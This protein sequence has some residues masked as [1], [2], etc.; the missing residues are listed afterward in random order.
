MQLLA[1]ILQSILLALFLMQDTVNLAPFNNLAAQI[2]RLGWAKTILGTC[3]TAGCAAASLYLTI[4]YR[5]APLPLGAKLFFVLW[6]GM[7][8]LGMWMAWYQPYFFG[9]SAKD[10]E[11][12]HDLFEGTHSI[13]PARHGFR[14]PN[15]LHLVLHFFMI[16]C[17]VLGLLKVAGGY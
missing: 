8:M 3:I 4:K 15:T 17:A 1:V 2:R 6:W 13:L 16:A 10:L 5:G 7:L 11:L 14:G 12:Y 9:P